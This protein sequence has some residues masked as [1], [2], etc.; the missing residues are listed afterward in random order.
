MGR[1]G[2][3]LCAF[4]NIIRNIFA[5]N[6]TSCLLRV[7]KNPGISTCCNIFCCSKILASNSSCDCERVSESASE[8]G[9]E[10]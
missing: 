2:N 1:K 10:V 9:S 7:G 4:S 5:C 8:G 3:V 6:S